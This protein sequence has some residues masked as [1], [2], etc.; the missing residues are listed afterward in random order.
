MAQSGA[1]LAARIEHQW[2]FGIHESIGHVGQ[3]IAISSKEA[4]RHLLNRIDLMELLVKA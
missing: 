4:I 3:G 2:D 1:L